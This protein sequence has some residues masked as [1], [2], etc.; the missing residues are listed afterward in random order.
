MIDLLGFAI[1]PLALLAVGPVLYAI[2]LVK[3][4]VVK[5]EVRRRIRASIRTRR[6]NAAA[7]WSMDNDDE[8]FAL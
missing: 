7:G 1:G 4:G 8:V 6:I 5:Q 3:S 2:T